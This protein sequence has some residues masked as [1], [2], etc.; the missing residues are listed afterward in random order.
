MVVD[1]HTVHHTGLVIS[2][3]DTQDV[4]FDAVVESSG[5]NLDLFLRL[6][7]I[8]SE[9]IYLVECH[10]HKVI[11]YEE[12]T[13]TDNKTSC[14]QRH[15]DSLKRHS[16][17]LDCQKFVV[18][19]KRSQCHHRCQQCSK[20]KGKRQHCDATPG[21]E[22]QD[23]LETQS[24]SDKLIDIEPQELHHKNEHDDQKDRHERSYK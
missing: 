8:I 10:R 17:S 23:H 22:L 4:A 6:A 11:R 13:D 16:G 12:C 7:D 20:R 9:S 1:H 15:Q 5:R 2:L 18:L 24:L 14:T 19:P 3:V 21:K